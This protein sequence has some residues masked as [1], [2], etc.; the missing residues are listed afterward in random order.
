MPGRALL[1]SS[2]PSA[3]SWS[4]HS[5]TRRSRTA[6]MAR[7]RGD[8]S[9]PP[10]RAFALGMLALIG[11]KRAPRLRAFLLAFAVIDDIG[12]LMVIAVFYS[13]SLNLMALGCAVLGL[14]GIMLLAR[15][16]VWRMPPYVLLAVVTWYA[17]YRSG[18]HATLAGVLIALLM[19]VYPVRSADAT[20]PPRWPASTG[21]RRTPAPPSCYVSPWPTPCP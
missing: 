21:S 3:A 8:R 14:L 13:G 10:I 17:L 19:P 5:P 20:P 9:S 2:P 12:A 4:L 16:G 18:V 7:T 11:P 15:R 6:P 1:P